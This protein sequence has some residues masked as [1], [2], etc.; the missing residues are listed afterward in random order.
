MGQYSTYI[1]HTPGP[2]EG[3]GLGKTSSCLHALFISLHYGSLFSPLCQRNS[4]VGLG[5]FLSSSVLK[6]KKKRK[7]HPKLF[8]PKILSNLI[9][10]LSKKYFETVPTLVTIQFVRHP[11]TNRS[12]SSTRTIQPMLSK[13]KQIYIELKVCMT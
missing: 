9:F 3:P 5:G 8:L 11:Q 1:L 2:G 10:N 4:W 6:K 13:C 12:L 7:E